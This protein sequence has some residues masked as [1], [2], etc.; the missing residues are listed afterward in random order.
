MNNLGVHLL[1]CF[2][3][4]GSR[5]EKQIKSCVE[6]L[7]SQST[8]RSAQM[9]PGNKGY[10][11]EDA[12][13]KISVYAYYDGDLDYLLWQ[14]KS[15]KLL[16]FFHAERKYTRKRCHDQMVTSEINK[17][18]LL[19][20]H[21]RRI[22][23]DTANSGPVGGGGYP[24]VRSLSKSVPHGCSIVSRGY[25]QVQ[26]SIRGVPLWTDTCIGG[27]RDACPYEPQ[28][29]HFHVVFGEKIVK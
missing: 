23:Q 17:K 16:W 20:D 4:E 10:N 14:K 11:G 28:F 2:D 9:S 25:P 1:F 26:E 12:G 8:Q 18:F 29:F 21:K 5:I 7:S 19:R 22:A 27:N 15:T 6:D 24:L 3:F 13:D